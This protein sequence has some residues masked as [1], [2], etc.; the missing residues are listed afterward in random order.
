MAGRQWWRAYAEAAHDPK[1]LA[2]SDRDFRIWFKL[3]CLSSHVGAKPWSM[4][5]LRAWCGGRKDH[6]YASLERLI[7][8]G[9]IDV[10]EEGFVP[11]NWQ[12]RQYV[13]DISTPRVKRFRKRFRNTVTET[14]QS[15]AETDT[16]RKKERVGDAPSARA[17]RLPP[18]WHPG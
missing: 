18:D 17:A 5:T 14:H 10:V 9:L 16:E 12:G 15:R 8:A 3:L 1:L 4:T 11:H 7:N 13:S 6:I 2:L